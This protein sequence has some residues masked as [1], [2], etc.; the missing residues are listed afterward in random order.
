MATSLLTVHLLILVGPSQGMKMV[1]RDFLVNSRSKTLAPPGWGVHL[2]SSDLSQDC[3]V[4]LAGQT[5]SVGLEGRILF[6]RMY[7]DDM[8]IPSRIEL[9]FKSKKAVVRGQGLNA[10]FI[11]W[12]M[13][14]D[15]GS[16]SLRVLT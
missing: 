11:H 6:F 16:D 2:C 15:L 7:H 8:E 9:L 14:G 12:E 5:F 3:H 1:H 13:T 10:E 4:I